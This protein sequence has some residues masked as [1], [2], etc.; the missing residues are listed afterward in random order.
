MN[1]LKNV[2][3]VIETL[4]GT[5]AAARA[6]GVGSQSVSNWKAY[7]KFPANQFVAVNTLLQARDCHAGVELFAFKRRHKK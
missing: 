1:T 3:A 2:D 4:G 7:N 6:I 5:V